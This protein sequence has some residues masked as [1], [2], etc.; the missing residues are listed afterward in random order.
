MNEKVNEQSTSEQG[1]PLRGDNP[2]KNPNEDRLERAGVA[3]D[4]ARHVLKLDASEGAVVG[5]F[6]P[7]GSGKTSFINLARSTFEQNDVPVFDFNPWMF[8]GTKQLVER[9]FAELSSEMKEKKEKKGNLTTIGK[10]FANYGT[11]FSPTA[12]AV[13]SILAGPLAGNLTENALKAVSEAAGNVTAQKT[14]TIALRKEITSAL[15]KRCNPIVVVLDDVDRLSASEIREMFKLVRLTANFPHIIY[16]IPCDR[17]RIEK[18]LY[19]N[20]ISGRDYLEKIIQY[21]FKLPEAPKHL[22]EK[23][24]LREIE[25]ILADMENIDSFEKDH[26]KS[27][28]LPGIIQPLIRNMRDVR[29]YTVAIRETLIGIKGE[30]LLADVLGLEAIRIFLPD[31]FELLP[32]ASDVLTGEYH[33]YQELYVSP[34]EGFNKPRM[35]KIKSLIPEVKNNQND[36]NSNDSNKDFKMATMMFDAWREKNVVES[37]IY[38]LFPNG[39]KLLKKYYGMQRDSEEKNEKSLYT[40]RVGHAHILRR[41]LE[42]V[43]SPGLLDFYDAEHS[44]R[45]MF[46]I[47]GFDNFLRQSISPE[48]WQNVIRNLLELDSLFLPTQVK[49]GITVLLNLWPDMPK[50]SSVLTT[51]SIKRIIERLLSVLNTSS[52]TDNMINRIWPEVKS[53]SSKLVF[54]QIVTNNKTVSGIAKQEFKNKF[55]NEIRLE[56]TNDPEKFVNEHALS[57]I[58]NFAITNIHPSEEKLKIPDL[59][60]LTFFLIQMAHKKTT[61]GMPPEQVILSPLQL[62]CEFLISLYGGKDTLHT[63]V[64]ELR[65]QFE[66]LKPWIEKQEVSLSRAKKLIALADA[67]INEQQTDEDSPPT[68]TQ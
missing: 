57:K 37:M 5:V 39:D 46:T 55:L 59:P 26:W 68:E 4:F 34:R 36:K 13:L 45:Y 27:M 41:Y 21:P 31:I 48:R 42:R 1:E 10:A 50:P 60:K 47:D 44:V 28:V 19:E 33:Q 53:L 6:G 58:L 32:S 14:S 8:S 22:L 51:M 30:V 29:R 40:R 15:E 66:N 25:K 35:E 49:P 38:L 2:I 9:F 11:A 52:A 23:E 17:L 7:W 61:N 43:V 62:D 16:I 56:S 63:R 54:L 67:C 12:G 65:A 20:G 24:L 3:K 18:A 64:K